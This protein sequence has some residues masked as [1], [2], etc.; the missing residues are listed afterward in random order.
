M[1]RDRSAEALAFLDDAGWADA[2]LVALR[3][4]ASTRRY[5]RVLRN[6]RS[7]MLMDQP[8]SAEAPSCPHSASPEERLALGYNAVA[9][10]AGANCARF[11]A[12][13]NYLRGRGLAAPDIYA[14]NVAQ[15]FVLL[16]DFGDDL[17]A[18]ALGNGADQMALY[19]TATDAIARLHREAAPRRI[20]GDTPLYEY[21][22]H[23]Q[24]AEVDLMT[25]WFVPLA[26]RRPAV[27]DEVMEHQALWRETLA[28]IRA[29]RRVF[30]HRD[31]HA[32]NLFWLPEREG[33]ARVGMIDFQDA[34]AGNR[35]YDLVSLLE[36]ARR[37]VPPELARAMRKRYLA[38]AHADGDAIDEEAFAAE[39]AVTAAQR[40]TK[41]AG[42]FA[43]LARRDGKHRYLSLVPRVWGYLERDLS[44]P[45]L[46]RLRNWYDRVIPAETRCG[47]ETAEAFA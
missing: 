10:L 33:L 14:A 34:L 46:A 24:L 36:D 19:S 17:Y 5:Y 15:G 18:D 40:N 25:E 42:I 43:R 29:P 37:D 39:A 38:A 35:S 6:G 27:A 12:T 8:Q 23:A 7:A 26:L 32:Q 47:L 4:D 21:D 13:A 31:Y 16:E 2:E 41:I 44:H 45:I 1:I 22:L 30:V 20:A 9:R 3:G 11:I 28:A